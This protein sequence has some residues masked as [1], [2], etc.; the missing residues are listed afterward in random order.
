MSENIAEKI[1]RTSKTNEETAY[2][3]AELLYRGSN[4]A[5]AFELLRHPAEAGHAECQWLLGFLYYKGA[6]ASADFEQA[7]YWFRK[8]AD[9]GL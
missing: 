8:S 9:Q 4:Y 6:G 3:F 7:I 5:M 1:L 2:R